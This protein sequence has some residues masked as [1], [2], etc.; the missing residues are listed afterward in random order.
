MHTSSSWPN[1]RR[2]PESDEQPRLYNVMRPNYLVCIVAAAAL[3]CASSHADAQEI[4]RDRTLWLTDQSRPF[5]LDALSGRATVITMAY[6]ACRRICA[7]SL[8]IMEN[9]QALADQ[10]GL[11]LNFV[12]VGLDPRQDKPADWASFRTE[13]KLTR[14]NWQFL[15]GD[16]AA[17]RRIAQ[18]LGVHYWQYDEH[19][20]HDFRIVLL[21]STGRLLSSMDR[22]DDPLARVL[23]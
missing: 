12:V 11:D 21:S 17:T 10:R 19:V 7:T 18:Q 23:P 5:R 22:F 1:R 15:S 3:C 16:E 20:M 14:A 8:R 4:Y 9:L 6:G 2:D 13:R